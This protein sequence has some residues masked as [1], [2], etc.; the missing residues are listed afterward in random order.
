M[1]IISKAQIDKLH[2][3]A[4]SNID[5]NRPWLIG[6]APGRLDVMGGIAD[7]SG[8]LVLQLPLAEAAYAAVQKRCDGQVV[9]ISG[10]TNDLAGIHLVEMPIA[11]IYRHIADIKTLHQILTVNP[12]TA[13][14]SY[15]LGVVVIVAQQ[16]NIFLHDG[17]TIVIDS[18]VPLGKGVSSSAAIEVATMRALLALVGYEIDGRTLAMWSQMVEN[19]IVG[20]PCGIMDQMTSACGVANQ[21]LALRCQPAELLDA[22]ALPDD[23]QVWGIDSGVRHAVTG[24]DYTTVRVAAFM[25]YRILTSLLGMPTQIVDGIA[26]IDDSRWYGY[27]ANMTPSELMHY[28]AQLPNHLDGGSFLRHYQATHDTVTQINP[29]QVYPVRQA[30]AH[31][32]FEHQRV[33]LFAA[34]LHHAAV[35][36]ER[37]QLLGEL[38]YQAHESY[39]ACGLGADATDAI[40]AQVRALG[41]A[42]GLYGAKITG[43]G[44]GGTVAVLGRPDAQPLVQHIASQYGTGMLFAGSSD[45]AMQV[46]T[47]MIDA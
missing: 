22:V 18:Q 34:L 10:A 15:L 41:P 20:A 36:H 19:H 46:A 11:E 7:Y 33:R 38:M 23:L 28:Y 35:D 30:T 43:G 24:A 9:V 31:P 45:G 3:L 29:H 37:A 5:S 32:I 12:D 40:V 26:H 13:W 25:G 27:L 21:L 16:A 42:H 44:S 4:Q 17:L 8:S 6:R 39:N 14:A 1:T 2:A 47:V